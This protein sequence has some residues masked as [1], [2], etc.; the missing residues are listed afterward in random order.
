[1]KNGM[2]IVGTIIMAAGLALGGWFMGN[3][4]FKGRASERF[5]TVKGVSERDVHADIGLWPIR[6]VSTDDD[7]A[8][9]QE[10]NAKSKQLILDFLKRHSIEQEAIHLQRLSVNDL[11]ANPYRS[12][13]TKSRYIINQTLMVRTEDPGLIQK[14]SQD[15]GE[16]VKAGVVLSSEGGMTNVPT[17]LFTRLSQMKPEM[18][19]EAT[20]NARRAA[21]QFAKDS[22]SQI[23]KIRRANQGV[24]VILPRD[25]APGIME[26]SQLGKTLRVVS[27][28]QYNLKD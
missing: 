18:I 1:M 11:L 22:G 19:A 6:F 12:G 10:K 17:Y 21:E 8:R 15:V 2:I 23:G 7:L 20:A 26:G 24:F 9:A 3:G 27:T 14:A 4:F 5:V 13:S 16:L 25:R 28:I